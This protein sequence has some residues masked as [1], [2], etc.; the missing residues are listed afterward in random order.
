M[1][2]PRRSQGLRRRPP[3]VHH[4]RSYPVSG[5]SFADLSPLGEI[6]EE[7]LRQA[8]ERLERKLERVRRIDA[9]AT[10]EVGDCDPRWWW[11]TVRPEAGFER[12]VDA[13]PRVVALVDISRSLADRLVGH[14][15][16][17]GAAAGLS[18]AGRPA[19]SYALPRRDA[20]GPEDRCRGGPVAGDLM[21]GR[22]I[23][24]GPGGPPFEPSEL[25]AQC[26]PTGSRSGSAVVE[27]AEARWVV[28]A[29]SELIED[30][31]PEP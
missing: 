20:G 1:L 25:S 5:Y 24:G 7:G 15:R 8:A 31:E 27:A 3:P 23:N 2:V 29:D 11:V 30:P 21:A 9:R 22:G 6:D 18:A 28:V 4:G 13:V 26:A 16:S 19:G 17:P 10:G 12:V 14:L